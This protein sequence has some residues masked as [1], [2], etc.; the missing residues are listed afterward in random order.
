MSGIEIEVKRTAAIGPEIKALELDSMGN[1]NRLPFLDTTDGPLVSMTCM[2]RITI[3]G[4][5]RRVQFRRTSDTSEVVADPGR[6]RSNV[7][8]ISRRSQLQRWEVK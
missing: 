6:S 4:G 1:K 2:H 7:A 5:Q 8:T 3:H